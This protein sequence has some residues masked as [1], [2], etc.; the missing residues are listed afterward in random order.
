[1]SI[2][3]ITQSVKKTERYYFF[4]IHVCI[5]S[6]FLLSRGIRRPEF[7]VPDSLVFLHGF[8]HVFIIFILL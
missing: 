3:V 6:L 7:W 4:G 2:C 8:T 5:P 1:M